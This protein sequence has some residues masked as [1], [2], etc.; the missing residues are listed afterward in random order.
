MTAHITQW[1]MAVGLSAAIGSVAMAQRAAEADKQFQ[2]ASHLENVVGDCKGAIDEYQKILVRPGVTTELQASA[3][4]HMAR[5]YER[6]GDTTRAREAYARLV[7]EF[8]DQ[9]ITA[10]ARTS[11]AALGG[12]TTSDRS[13]LVTGDSRTSHVVWTEPKGGIFGGGIVSRDGQLLPYTDWS[14]G[15][16]A[17]HEL[18]TGRDRKLTSTAS[19][20]DL[21]RQ[22]YAGPSRVSPDGK[23]IAYAWLNGERYDLRLLEVKDGAI[24]QPRVL[25]DNAEVTYV[26]PYDW[27]PDGRL[28]AVQIMRRDRSG[29]IGLLSVSDGRL[30]VL[31]SFAWRDQ[32]V[33]MFFSPDGRAIGYD[34]PSEEVPGERDVHVLSVDGARNVPVAPH[35]RNDEMVGWSADGKRLLFASDRTGSLQLWAQ[36][37]AGLAPRGQPSV[38]ASDFKGHAYGISNTGGLYYLATTYESS[39]FRTT[40]FD[41]ETGRSTAAAVDPGE[42]FYSINNVAQAAWSA[43]G[44]WLALSRRDRGGP[45]GILISVLDAGGNVVRNVRP[46]LTLAFLAQWAVDGTSFIMS[47]SD[48]RG[49]HGVFRVDAD[50]GAATPLLLSQEEARVNAPALS[51]DG[52]HMYYRVV[53]QS[54]I[55][56]V[57]RTIA[58]GSEREIVRRDREPSDRPNVLAGLLLSPDGRQILTSTLEKTTSEVRLLAVSVA[59]GESREVMRAKAAPEVLIW[60]P[61]SRSVFIRQAPAAGPPE[62]LRVPVGGGEPVKIDWSPG[63]DTADFRVHPDG[64]RVVFVRTTG[65]AA[66]SELRVIPGIAR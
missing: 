60:A 21:S 46:Q 32:S 38:I 35:R 37:M 12:A 41:F 42:E 63:P 22:R 65:P 52:T 7:R 15:D 28:L 25:Y 31:T 66:Q 10:D 27:S 9:K 45:A 34:L 8:G 50:S 62:V 29:Q 24:P 13:N 17:V 26:Q 16:L 19:F 55:R 30:T 11:L 43:D 48:L 51:P 2:A 61:D 47:G 33:N 5:C 18:S 56:I 3:L 58:S 6:L 57:D 36:P 64:R 39:P 44:H 1:F 40:V 23:R 14:T 54:A 20:A 59:T 49:R 53:T 4:M